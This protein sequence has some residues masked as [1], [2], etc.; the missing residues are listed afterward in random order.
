MAQP[1]VAACEA[2]QAGGPLNGWCITAGQVELTITTPSRDRTTHQPTSP[3]EFMQR[4][5]AKAPMRRGPGLSLPLGAGASDRRSSTKPE[6]QASLVGRPE[7]AAP[8][9]TSPEG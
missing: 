1:P 9:N 4:L 7:T 5:T 8:T 6:H 3:L 2:A